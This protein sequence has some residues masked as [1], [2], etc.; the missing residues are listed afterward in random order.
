MIVLHHSRRRSSPCLK[1]PKQTESGP[2]VISVDQTHEQGANMTAKLIPMTYERARTRGFIA[3]TLLIAANACAASPANAQTIGDIVAITVGGNSTGIVGQGF[4]ADV[5][6]GAVTPSKNSNGYAYQSIY[7]TPVICRGVQGCTSGSVTFAL[8]GLAANPGQNYLNTL[9]PQTGVSGSSLAGSTAGYSYSGGTAQWTWNGAE[10]TFSGSTA[11]FSVTHSAPPE[12]YL[13]VKYKI[14]GV[15][16]A[17]PGTKSFVSYGNSLQIGSNT[18]NSSS[19]TTAT[20]ESISIGLGASVGILAAGSGVTYTT[21]YSQEE[22]TSSSIALSTTSTTTDTTPGAATT[23]TG[24]DH[25]YDIVWVWLNP[26]I[27]LAAGNGAVGWLG[28]AYNPEDNAED[29]MEVV[30]LYVYELKDPGSIATIDPDLAGRLSRAWDTTGLGGLTSADYSTILAADPLVSSAYN[31]AT[32]SNHRFDEES[33][34]GTVVYEPPP[35]GG[36]PVTTGYTLSTQATTSQGQG[37][38]NTYST[39]YKIDLKTSAS[40]FANVSISLESSNT[41]TTKDAWSSTLNST[42]GHTATL[43][44]TGPASAITGPTEYQV[45]RDNVYGSFMFYPVQ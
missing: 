44:I 5:P 41:Y 36:S 12:G 43:S 3:A 14:V 30:G 27:E 24:I 18:A 13:D 45:W 22:D 7:S 35:P 8:S 38:S 10:F 32:D 39:G 21:S 2:I 4:R 15:T 16:Y 37:A 29:G 17:P 40:L 28:Y 34:L 25:D 11:T 19:F 33:A 31:P 6:Y 1:R 20:S 42:T 23:S 9:T 26:E